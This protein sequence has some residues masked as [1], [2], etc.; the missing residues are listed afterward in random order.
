MITY[1][2]QIS[3]LFYMKRFFPLIFIFLLLACG[4][5]PDLLPDREVQQVLI[6]GNSITHHLPAPHIGWYGSWGMAASAP[7]RDYVSILRH[8]LQQ[9]Y[10]DVEVT[11]RIMVDFEREYYK[12]DFGK[13]SDLE[14]M[15]TDILVWRLAENITETDFNTF[16][17]AGPVEQ[18]VNLIRNKPHMRVIF[19]TSFWGPDPLNIEMKRIAQ[20]N[21]WELV[22]LYPLGF[23]EKYRAIGKFE[24]EGVAIHPGDLGMQK[25]ADMIFDQI[26]NCHNCK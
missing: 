4:K 8:S 1:F 6:L 2:C 3:I 26:K 19:T 14:G 18:V 11:T 16:D 23:E 5:D 15:D 25:I 22:D 20:T 24:N 7:E 13:L 21:G 12:Y 17:L 9:I 10:P